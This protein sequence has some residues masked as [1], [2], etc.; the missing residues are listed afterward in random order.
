M[1]TTITFT[2]GKRQTTAM[3]LGDS[4]DE[5]Q[6]I[7]LD[8]YWLLFLVAAAIFLALKAA[9]AGYSVSDENTYYKMGQLVAAGQVP[10]RD[11]FFAHT[12]LQ[13]YLYAAVFEVFGF[14]LLLLKLLS[15]VAVIVTAAFVFA[16]VKEKLNSAT[17]M[18]AAAIFM[19]SYGTLLFSNF[20]TG[21]ELAV[22]FVVA[23]FYFFQ[24]KRF[25][26][27]GLLMG[28]AAMTYQLSAIAFAVL[29][30]IAALV[31][32]DRRAATRL[33]LGFF[34]VA[35]SVSAIFLI[36]AKG[37]F[38]RQTLLYHLQK[39]SEG[40]DKAA[41][42]LRILKTNALL[43]IAAAIALI[44]R[45]RAKTTVA[46]PAALAAAYIAI[47]PLAKTAFNY[48]IIYALPFLAIMAAYGINSVYSLFAGKLKL[49][50]VMS[51]IAVAA[52]I[53]ASAFMAGRQF[54]GYHSQDFPE[55]EEISAY[56]RSN[57][58]PSQTIF[59]DDSTVPLLSLLSGR[60]IA[61]N[62]ADNN[63]MRYKAG[64]PTLESALQQLE[65]KIK[66]RELKLIVLRRIETSK[67]TYDFGIGTERQFVK[68]LGDKCGL[69]AQ[70][71]QHRIYDC[72]KT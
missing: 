46:I 25:L 52:I 69:A 38:L 11:F 36:A 10:Y 48:Y 7:K 41:L 17:A 40:A 67:G 8:R 49:T 71:G 63:A 21:A 58:V 3:E 14:N 1:T 65:E 68:F 44:G 42:L 12:P 16:I 20:P 57:S 47:F 43:F 45:E 34:A 35:G 50:R 29:A 39:P 2:G 19:F 37:E 26:L 31:L 70:F 64:Q 72:L 53:F 56:V 55:A 22:P 59:G 4:A 33:G 66:S 18:A 13:V 6:N 60:E 30:A 51:L 24:R 28:F 9:N 27:A 23:A 15:A 32:R 61:L 5:S 54:A 62:H